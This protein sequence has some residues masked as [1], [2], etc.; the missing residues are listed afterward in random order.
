MTT[1]TTHTAGDQEPPPRRS[2]LKTIWAFLGVI[3]AGEFL[4]IV[5]GFL[6]P[7]KKTSQT[8]LPET[9]IEAGKLEDFPIGSVTAFVRGRFYLSRLEDG[10]V[11]AISRKCTHLGCTVP[12]DDEEKKFICPCHASAF[13]MAGDVISPPAPRP[14]DIH[15]V[16]IE[17]GVITVNTS[18]TIRRNTLDAS[19]IAYA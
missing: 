9:L 2:F 3:A 18:R 8:A 1:H 4:W 17:N 15:P 12:W 14:L 13:D 11:L 7:G 19:Q 5:S 10:G 16:S 6:K